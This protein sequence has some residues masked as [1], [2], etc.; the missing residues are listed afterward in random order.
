MKE[1]TVSNIV[2]VAD[3]FNPSLFSQVWLDKYEILTEKEYKGD[4]IYTPVFAQAQSDTFSLQVWPERLQFAY[5]GDE[6][7]ATDLICSKVGKIVELLPHTPYKALGINFTWHI[8]IDDD[9]RFADFDRSIFWN[10]SAL[11]S[12]FD[13]EDARFGGYFSKDVLETR[14]RLDIKPIVK[15]DKEVLQAAFNFQVDLT[16]GHAVELTQKSL[17]N[18]NTL[19]N[20]SEEISDVISKVSSEEA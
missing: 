7:D 3:K 10:N 17:R 9:L 11:H 2:V 18:W 8:W 16:K 12:S 5:K 1:L 15:K 4:Q 6:E 19:K 20:N 13:S 14:L